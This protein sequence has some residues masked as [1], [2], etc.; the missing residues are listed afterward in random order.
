MYDQH[1][2]LDFEMNPVAKRYVEVR[3]QLHREII[4]IGA[5]KL[6]SAG[7][8]LETFSCFVKPEYSSDVANYITKLTGIKTTDVYRAASFGEA[9]QRFSEWVGSGRTRIYSWGDSDQK[10]LKSECALK[11]VPFPANMTRWMDFQTI[12][13]RLMEIKQYKRLMSL[14]EAAEWYGAAFD[15]R[16]A[17]RALYDAKVT[18]ELVASVLTG[19]YISQR[20]CLKEAIRRDEREEKSAGF[21]LVDLCSGFFSQLVTSENPKPGYAR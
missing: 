13:P 15:Q 9:I 7:E 11:Q 2:I 4:E 18:T 10:Q 1:V 12:F 14:H 8:I 17:H 6:N 16:D 19:E 3:R 5:V 21:S 20:D